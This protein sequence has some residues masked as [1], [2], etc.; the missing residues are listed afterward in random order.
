MLFLLGS[1]IY[2]LLVLVILAEPYNTY[3]LSLLSQTIRHLHYLYAVSYTHLDVYKRQFYNL[4]NIPYLISIV[5]F[6]LISKVHLDS[7][8][9]NY[10][11]TSVVSPETTL[12]PFPDS[13]LLYGC[14]YFS[15]NLSH[16]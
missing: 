6:Q 8:T 11:C 5:Y 4:N 15:Y 2:A 13:E 1:C 12:S 16:K 9:L 14:V 7:H 3:C 10:S